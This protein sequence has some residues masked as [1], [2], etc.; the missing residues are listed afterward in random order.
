M[1]LRQPQRGGNAVLGLSFCAVAAGIRYLP[2][3]LSRE[4]EQF[5]PA[6]TLDRMSPGRN[7]TIMP[8]SLDL[9]EQVILSLRRITR[10]VDVHSNFLQRAYGLTGPQLTA[11]RVVA[12]L[13]PVSAGNL[14]RDANIGYATL[15]GILD[16]LEKHELVL[17]NR[18]PD[19]RRTVMISMTEAGSRLLAA[20]PSLLQ[21]SLCRELGRIPAAERTTLL[22]TLVRVA[23]LMEADSAPDLEGD[24]SRPNGV[25]RGHTAAPQRDMFPVTLPGR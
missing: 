7:Q 24:R 19:D 10:A 6:L 20:A 5:P 17:R 11:L 21:T 22:N 16:R 9:E 3:W 13:Q 25:S 1:W 18:H 2:P 15:T 4:W 23:E 12:R 8:N 14:A